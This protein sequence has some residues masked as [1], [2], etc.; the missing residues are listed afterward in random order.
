MVPLSYADEAAAQQGAK[1]RDAWAPDRQAASSGGGFGGK[2]KQA[3]REGASTAKPPKEPHAKLKSQRQLQQQQQQQQQQHNRLV[4]KASGQ[5]LHSRAAALVPKRSFFAANGPGAAVVNKQPQHHRTQP[6]HDASSHARLTVAH[7]QAPR[8]ARPAA[9]NAAAG[10]AVAKPTGRTRA[11]G[12]R[13][14]RKK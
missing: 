5:Q 1:L 10:A 13:K 12:G 7:P 8:G 3:R 9:A 2:Q 14:R 6:Q 4:G 11:E